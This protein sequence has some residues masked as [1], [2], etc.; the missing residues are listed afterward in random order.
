VDY[1]N[2]GA[3]EQNTMKLQLE[4]TC[5]DQAENGSEQYYCHD[6]VVLDC[7]S[8]ISQTDLRSDRD[9]DMTVYNGDSFLGCQDGFDQD[10][11]QKY[12]WNHWNN[13]DDD[14]QEGNNDGEGRR[15]N[16]DEGEDENNGQDEQEDENNN[17]QDE[18]E[19]EN[20]NSQDEEEENNSQDEQEDE[21]NGQDEQEEEEENNNEENEEQEDEDENGDENNA[22]YQNYQDQRPYMVIY[23]N[24]NTCQVSK[25]GA[26]NLYKAA[27]NRLVIPLWVL[28]SVTAAVAGYFYSIRR[29]TRKE[30]SAEKTAQLF[31]NGAAHRFDPDE[32][33]R[34]MA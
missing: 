27:R 5:S 23:G 19:D 31:D 25:H 18:Q 10:T 32:P 9:Y 1:Y 16:E 30:V 7:N 29:P 15:L 11:W 17:S 8:G 12:N 13:N 26:G 28:T 34:C 21:N 33:E 14:A 20:D 3:Y 2:N 4:W 22:S 6:N 24:C